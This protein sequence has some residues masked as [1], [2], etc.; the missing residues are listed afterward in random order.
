MSGLEAARWAA[1]LV[2]AGSPGRAMDLLAPHLAVF[3]L[4][5]PHAVAVVALLA[6]DRPQDAVRVAEAAMAAFAAD[7]ELARVSSYAF[8]AVGQP[9]RGLEAAR[10]AVEGMPEWVPGLLALV[11][12]QLGVGD[13]D[14]AQASL[15][16]AVALA[17]DRTEVWLLSADLALARGH[18]GAARA[19]LLTALRLDPTSV[20]AMRGLGLVEERRNRYGSAARWYAAALRLSPGD[21]ALATALRA[22]FGRVLGVFASTL[23]VVGLVAFMAFMIVADPQPG[24]A[25]TGGGGPVFWVLWFGFGAFFV[26]LARYSLR[27]TPRVVLAALAAETR[28][29]RRVRRCVRLVVAH[30]A[31][32][33]ATV[34]VAVAPFGAP[35]DRLP[36]VFLIW[37]VS[38]VLLCVLCVALRVTFGY[39]QTRAA[40]PHPRDRVPAGPAR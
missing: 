26:G 17:P 25:A 40:R 33:A 39:G 23:V 38:M 4:P 1:M 19:H 8:R 24:A 18:A 2:E 27:G 35:S 5:A 29:Y 7:P 12:A 22:L 10:V 36:V 13:R 32:V 15:A 21:Q 34:L 11:A 20:A 37:L 28:S 6:L 30:G 14:A 3:D 16:A 9:E 31:S